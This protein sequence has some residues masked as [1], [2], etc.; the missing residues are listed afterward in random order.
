VV[1]LSRLIATKEQAGCLAKGPLQVDVADLGVLSLHPF[2]LASVT[3][4]LDTANN[5]WYS[6]SN[7]ADE[8]AEG[9]F[10]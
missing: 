5:L 6:V 7:P 4:S 9:F 8:A 1:A 2:P 3:V 10:D